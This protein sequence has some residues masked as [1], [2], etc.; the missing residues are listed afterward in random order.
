MNRSFPKAQLLLILPLLT[1]PAA[2]AQ[3][4]LKRKAPVSQFEYSAKGE[5]VLWREASGMEARELFYGSGGR[6]HQPR[7]ATFQF[8][9]EDPDGTNPK[10]TVRD[11]DGVK[12][13][14][15]LGAEARPET[16]ATRLVWAAGYFTDEDYFLPEVRVEG[17]PAKLHRGQNLV[18]PGGVL[19]NARL[20][21]DLPDEK[22]MGIWKWKDNPFA[23]TREWNGLRVLMALMNNWDLKNENNAVYRA[24]T[25][26]GERLLYVVSDLGATFGPTRLDLHRRTDKGDLATYRRTSFIR[27]TREQDVDFST[28]GLPSPIFIFMPVDYFRRAGLTWTGRHVPRAD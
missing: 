10:F 23:G 16:V 2:H 18:E 21:R 8:G 9:K 19:R 26:D 12:W 6:E 3:S 4:A 20:E 17:L 11:A 5:K 13:K 15:K 14:I 28:P 1:G 27:R 25:K 24:K 22:K 7:G